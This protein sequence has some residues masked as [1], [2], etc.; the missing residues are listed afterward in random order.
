M[1]GYLEPKLR[2]F[3]L[4][5]RITDK[6]Q[7]GIADV[8]YLE[9]VTMFPRSIARE[10]WFEM[11]YLEAWPKRDD[12]LSV[13]DLRPDQALF[14]NA[15]VRANAR[16]RAGILLRVGTGDEHHD[17]W[18]YW[19]AKPELEWLTWIRSGD[20]LNDVTLWHRYGLE[21][22]KLVDELLT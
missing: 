7:G 12:V 9:R 21:V 10:G 22:D 20:V 2:P 6:L 3:L 13:A 19:R 4:T 16:A 15:R 5:T 11:K 18:L 14:L 8:N 1:W 17:E